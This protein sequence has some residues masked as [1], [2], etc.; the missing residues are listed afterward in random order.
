VNSF[1]G[2]HVDPSSTAG[3]TLALA[4]AVVLS[5]FIG[6]EREMHGHPAGWRTHILVC[7]GS[8]LITLVSVQIGANSGGHAD[9]GR[10]AAQVVSGIGFLG[11]G[12]IIR[13][14]ASIRGLTTAASVWTTAGI[15]IA[16]GAS[17][18]MAQIAVITT[19]IVLFTLLIL[20]RFE[21]RL[22]VRTK[23]IRTI[24]VFV[25]DTDRASADVLA[26]IAQ[27]KVEVIG[28]EY[29]SGKRPHERQILMRVRFPKDFNVSDFVHDVGNCPGV[30]SVSV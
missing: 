2:L 15:G 16:V 24:E 7:V 23:R 1:F 12:A 17:P 22:D 11:A 30:L 3:M 9:P 19:A 21:D 13:E 6:L 20:N 26:R 18:F 10:L 4:I 5:G 8:T 25:H 14:G 27:A 29:A 28:V